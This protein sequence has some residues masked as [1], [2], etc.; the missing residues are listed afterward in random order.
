[1][2]YNFKTSSDFNPLKILIQ[3]NRLTRNR[4]DY[5]PVTM[6]M[7]CDMINY[8]MPRKEEKIYKQINEA[9]IAEYLLG[10]IPNGTFTDIKSKADLND[11]VKKLFY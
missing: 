2:F 3:M 10:F 11:P 8:M 6:E 5:M 9:N 7:V 1:M 4:S